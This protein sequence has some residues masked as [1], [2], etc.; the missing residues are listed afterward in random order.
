MAERRESVAGNRREFGDFQTPEALARE[1]CR[2]MQAVG[3]CPTA[4]LEPTCGEGGF[5]A[6]GIATFPTVAAAAGFDIDEEYVAAAQRRVGL[7]GTP[8]R[9][10]AIERGDFFRTDWN[11]VLDSL[12][13]PV[14]VLGNPPWVT[15]SALG[16]IGSTNL[17]TKSNFQRRAGLDAI[18]GKSNFDISEWILIRLI[19]SLQDRAGW[20]GMLCKTGVARKVLLH[21]W[22]GST[23][24]GAAQLHRIDAT[25]HFGAAVDA[26]FLLIPCGPD[27][28]EEKS[29]LVY[30]SCDPAALPERT[31]GYLDGRLVADVERYQN[32]RR[33]R[34]RS[35][36]HIWRSGVKHDCS[37]VMELTQMPDGR[38]RNGLGAVVDLE[39]DYVYPMLKSSHVAN[40]R[41]SDNHRWMLVTQSE[42]GT[43][44]AAIQAIAPKT[45]RYLNEHAGYLDRRAS[46]IYKR[47]PRFCVFG[48]GEYTFAPWKVAVSGFYKRLSF[49]VV[50]PR[51]GKPTVLDDTSYFLPCR[52]LEDAL[53]L[54]SLLE[55][56]QAR[57]FFEAAVFW[58]SKRPI[59]ADVLN[60]LNI[61]ALARELGCNIP[62]GA[63]QTRLAL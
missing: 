22:Q 34:G 45:W 33:L 57:E 29:C 18:T 17:P 16:S 47:R 24:V 40:D 15:N 6:A 59:T 21:A 44:T 35:E 2:L 60:S 54:R 56:E 14:L 20:L 5:L 26:C 8:D 50:G 32:A 28:P 46:T 43:D 4:L 31:L 38:F 61:E 58:D 30:P 55:S 1:C 53:T 39:S 10:V 49:K 13:A 42:P 51:F 12:P 9:T 37:K 48:V 11:E 7:N 27:V 36:A 23:R 63:A 62:E 41:D 3:V 19:D 25:R 52:S